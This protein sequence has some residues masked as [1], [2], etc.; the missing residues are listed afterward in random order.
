MATCRLKLLSD[1][2]SFREPPSDAIIDNTVTCIVRMRKI[3]IA[4][5][6]EMMCKTLLA[7]AALLTLATQSK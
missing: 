4:T 5:A 1:M 7:L 6:T 3:N 2:Y